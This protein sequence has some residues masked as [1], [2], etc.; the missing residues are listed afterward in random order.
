MMRTARRRLGEVT[1]Q[2]YDNL[3]LVT[4]LAEAVG[5]DDVVAW[6]D[7]AV[8]AIED[9]LNIDG[10]PTDD[11]Q[12]LLPELVQGIGDALRSLRPVADAD[13]AAY[14]LQT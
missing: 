6:C 10:L 1:D 2:I 14:P 12:R 13:P 5:R 8:S 4:E 9:T 11:T 3:E 7:N